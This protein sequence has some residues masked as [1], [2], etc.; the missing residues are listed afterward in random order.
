MFNVTTSS[1]YRLH[2]VTQERIER[3][4]LTDN[5]ETGK[6]TDFALWRDGDSLRLKVYPTPDQAYTLKARIYIPQA[7]LASDDL[8]TVLSIPARMVWLRALFKAN[9]ERGSELGRP[10][11]SLYMAAMDAH[12]SAVG[13]EM[14]PDDMTVFLER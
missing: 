5:D 7:E 8:T 11:S 12:G 2:E 13:A 6:P 9:E 3:Y 10:G 14:R 1:E 4:H